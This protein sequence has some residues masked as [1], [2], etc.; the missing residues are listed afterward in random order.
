MIRRTNLCWDTDQPVQCFANVARGFGGGSTGQLSRLCK[1]VE[2][3]TISGRMR[4]H[5]ATETAHLA[6]GG[7]GVDGGAVGR[8]RPPRLTIV[9]GGMMEDRKTSTITRIPLL[10]DIPGLGMLFS[11]TQITKKPSC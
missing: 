3:G 11:R 4:N 9:I 6:G 10:G 5:G 8:I 2:H 1:A 7:D